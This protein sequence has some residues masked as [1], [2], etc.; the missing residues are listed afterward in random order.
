MND[1]TIKHQTVQ[2]KQKKKHNRNP[3]K[4]NWWKKQHFFINLRWPPP[5]VDDNFYI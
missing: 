3:L 5:F 4:S 1:K 2:N